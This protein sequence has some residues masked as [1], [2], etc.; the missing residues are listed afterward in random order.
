MAKIL[1]VDDERSIRDT[2]SGVLMDEGYDVNVAENGREAL[3]RLKD[4]LPSIVML[5]IWM[6]ELDGIETLKQIKETNPEL[7]VIM[8]SGHGTIEVAVKATRLGAYDFIEKPLSLEKVSLSISHALEQQ[9][10]T[11]ENQDLR[12][13][14]EKKYDIIGEMMFVQESP[15]R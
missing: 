8:M 2:L 9:R 13:R 4:E 10:L 11:E 14:I 6:P 3:K 1:I 5:D 15:T 12:R 7:P